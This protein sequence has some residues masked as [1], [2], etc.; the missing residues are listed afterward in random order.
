MKF[1]V[2]LFKKIVFHCLCVEIVELFFVADFMTL[3]VSEVYSI[4]LWHD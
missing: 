3:S 4:K 2:Y 1:R